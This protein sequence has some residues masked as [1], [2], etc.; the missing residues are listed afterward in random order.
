VFFEHPPNSDLEWLFMM[1][2]YGMPTRLL[3]WTEGYLIALY[4]A[5]SDRAISGDGVVW[6]LD[7]WSINNCAIGMDSVPTADHPALTSYSL[8]TGR[9]R[10]G[11]KLKAKLPV[12]VRPSRTTPRII[13]QRGTFTIHGSL[14]EGIEMLAQGTNSR[15]T[16]SKIRLRDIRIAGGKKSQILKQLYLAGVTESLVFPDLAGLCGEVSYRYSR[17]C[18]EGLAHPKKTR[19]TAAKTRSKRA[20]RRKTTEA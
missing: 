14:T 7:P 16:K 18:L 11:R 8:A 12:A 17:E 15:R 4:F 2:H 19:L 10:L 20:S 1:Q 6:V 5:V 13:A 9:D 3:D